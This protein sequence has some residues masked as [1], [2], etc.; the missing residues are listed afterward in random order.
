MPL[1]PARRS[2]DRDPCACSTSALSAAGGARSARLSR[3][4]LQ[5]RP[6][7]EFVSVKEAPAG[8]LWLGHLHCL[9]PLHPGRG[10]ALS[11]CSPLGHPSVG[12]VPAGAGRAGL[13]TATA[14]PGPDGSEKGRLPLGAA[15]STPAL[16]LCSEASGRSRCCI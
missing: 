9:S 5:M 12:A 4:S 7:W 1:L 13:Q 14:S 2:L 11:T 10:A 8:G 16:A 3:K 6:P 15:D